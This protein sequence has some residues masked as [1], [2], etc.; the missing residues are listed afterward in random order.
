MNLLAYSFLQGVLLVVLFVVCLLLIGIVLLQK[1]RG[2]GLA[3][4]F[5]GAGGGG[6]AFGAKTGDVFT[7]IT[8]ALALVFLLL[9]VVGNWVFSPPKASTT[10][11]T[12]STPAGVPAAPEGM[13]LPATEE[14]SGSDQPAE[15]DGEAPS[16]SESDETPTEV[17]AA[18][19]VQ[20][21]PPAEPVT[22][23]PAP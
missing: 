2:G 1:G 17:P 12:V 14:E 6:G 19:D 4:A 15:T 22:E 7:I 13:T 9:V 10:A 21:T 20:D 18:P 3:G 23:E 5:G 16:A 11:R 8:V